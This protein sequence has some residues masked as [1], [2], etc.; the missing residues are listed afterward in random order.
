MKNKTEDLTDQIISVIDP[1]GHATNKL[2]SAFCSAFGLPHAQ[3]PIYKEMNSFMNYLLSNGFTESESKELTNKIY[4]ESFN[5]RIVTNIY[6][7][8]IDRK[9]VSFHDLISLMEYYPSMYSHLAKV[10][11][12]ELL[13]CEFLELNKIGHAMRLEQNTPTAG[14]ATAGYAVIISENTTVEMLLQHI[15]KRNEWGYVGV[16]C[17]GHVFGSPQ[18]E[19]KNDQ[20]IVG[21]FKQDLLNQKITSVSA[22]GGW[23]RM[24]YLI[25][26]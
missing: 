10:R 19:Y 3:R 15:L 26:F 25:E 9:E 11:R 20:I 24:D 17:E 5:S 8:I 23:S 16:K 21:Q 14:D 6:R 12:K 7:C 18:I 2:G 4:R 22:R 13:Y 1:V